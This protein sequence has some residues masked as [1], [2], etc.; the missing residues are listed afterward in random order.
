MKNSVITLAAVAVAALSAQART[1]TP[2]EALGRA[3]RSADLPAAVASMRA[4][5]VVTP[6]YTLAQLDS[7]APALYVISRGEG[8]GCLVLSADD[9]AAPLLAYTDEAFDMESAPENF[10]WWLSQYQAEISEAVAQGLPAY[11]EAASAPSRAN[12]AP[13]CTTK[14][15]QDAP[16]WEKC[17]TVNGVHTYTGCVATAM[18]QVINYH[19]Y[20]AKGT[21]THS[22]TWNN[23]TLSFDY[24]NTTFDWA[25]ML[26]VY[27]S[28]ATTAQ[29][30]AVATLM[31]ACGVSVNMSYGT[32]AS[33]AV[34][35]RVPAALRDNFGFDKAVHY[36]DRLVYTSTGWE[37]L[38]YDQVDKCG[39]TYYS[40]RGESGG[41]AF[42]VDGYKDGYFHFN[43]GWS[44]VSDGYFRL[45]GLTPG[46]QGI[47]GNS[48]GFN[49]N[50]AIIADVRK[51]QADSQLALPY[52]MCTVPME[53]KVSGTRL[54]I[55]GP[56]LNY[57][58]FSFTGGY[59]LEYRDINTGE[60]VKVQTTTATSMQPLTSLQSI[61]FSA[62]AIP[63]GECYAYLQ[64]Y[65]GDVVAPI[66]FSPWNPGGYII[67][68]RNG[69]SISV[70]TPRGVLTTGE[71]TVVSP[72]YTNRLFAVD[73]PYTYTGTEDVLVAVIPQ[74]RNAAGTTVSTG[75]RFNAIVEPGQN[76]IQY[77][78][79]WLTSV[80]KGTYDL[81]MV[82]DAPVNSVNGTYS[83]VLGG[84]VSVT[85]SQQ[86]GATM[87]TIAAADW[88][89]EEAENVDPTH[90]T[91]KAN[92]NCLMG[93][94]AG[95]IVARIYENGQTSSYPIT[96]IRSDNVFI[97]GGQKPEVTITGEMLGGVAGQTYQMLLYTS[98]G[99]KL[100]TQP[101]SFVLG[102]ETGIESVVTGDANLPVE[103][104]N[105]QGQAVARPEAGTVVIRRQGDKVEKVI[106][107]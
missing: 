44:G 96:E 38:V 74:L 26:D 81:V 86:S 8:E 51:P 30:N 84:P 4:P 50:Q 21:G 42:V 107:K 70:E 15:D 68:K 31:Y 105:L 61:S 72:M 76:K 23:R 67:T 58:A 24:A 35:Q 66:H 82:S 83:D 32:G 29:K 69:T 28:S 13:K 27:T 46:T 104:F 90:L 20:P 89:I 65:N 10:K 59:R 1:L 63:Q 34:S 33:G 40:G 91:V 43:W 75:E 57:S 99:T 62:T 47:G 92:V 36:E 49:T 19:K 88:S 95:A 79:T 3:M 100:T 5:A 77:T 53:A 37:D 6:T 71:M 17:P 18:A 93:Y 73:I 87:L 39:P 54:T 97:A 16:Y 103:Y 94:F 52:I 64:V 12:I 102:S 80:A 25:N 11:D 101:K 98:E 9:V 41:H 22:Y 55:D 45:N 2:A 56:F 7:Q 85:L 60:V 14:W 78:G 106:V 48:D